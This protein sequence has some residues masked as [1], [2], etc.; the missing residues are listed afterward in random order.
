MAGLRMTKGIKTCLIVLLELQFTAVIGL[1][2]V[3][4]VGAG[5][6]V[7]LPC[8]NV[9]GDQKNC[10]GTTW[11]FT[12]TIS[13]CEELVV[14]GKIRDRQTRS[15]RLSVTETCSLVLKN[16]SSEDYGLY[17][18]RQF[19]P[20]HQ[21]PDT[22]VLLSVVSITEQKVKGHDE[23]TL[24]C[25]WSSYSDC[26]DKVKWLF[27]GA[28]VDKDNKDIRTSQ[29]LC[30]AAVRFSSS[31]FISTSKD[32]LLLTCEVREGSRKEKFTFRPQSSAV[33]GLKSVLVVGAGRDVTLP[34]KNVRGDQKNC[35]GTT[36]IFTQTTYNTQELV[37]LGKIRDR[38]TRSGRLSV[39]ETCSL[40][41][42]NVSSEDYGLYNC[43]QFKPEHQ[44]PDTEVL[45]SVVSI[46]EQKVGD[47]IVFLC[48]VLTYKDCIYSVKWLVDDD[49]DD[50]T[51]FIETPHSC[52][53]SLRSTTSHFQH[54]S[55]NKISLTCNVV[56]KSEENLQLS[57]FL[58]ETSPEETGKPTGWW[59]L[60]VIIAVVSGAFLI[61]AVIIMWRK[62]GGSKTQTDD[63]TRQ[64]LNPAVTQTAPEICQDMTVPE[65]AVAYASV[66]YTKNTSSRHQVCQVRDDD[67]SV[68]Y[69]TVKSPS[70]SAS[71]GPVNVYTAN[72][73]DWAAV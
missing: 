73:T 66:S 26:R 24:N 63:V 11:I 36:W 42:K 19:K 44:P 15:G 27:R 9:R 22:E 70:S 35:D 56:G 25:S 41:L 4:V 59:W 55:K 18:C 51:K 48:S 5:R 72:Q 45:L 38:Q 68:T 54:K 46:T 1:K 10:D 52:S 21:P 61:A 33:I 13:F 60:Y 28:D 67:D 39:T 58:P 23:V 14:L 17:N 30:S 64:S 37:V 8:E 31:H 6:D 7:T 49:E 20:E 2:S 3:L 53:A 43:R 71:S 50:S 40:V 16:V 69:S 62:T 34:C 29:F 12:Q 47:E 65:D 32:Y 57:A